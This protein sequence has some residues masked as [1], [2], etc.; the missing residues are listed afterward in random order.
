MVGKTS[1]KRPAASQAGSAAK[2]PHLEKG[3]RQ[4]ENADGALHKSKRRSRPVTAPV[5]DDSETDD[6]GDDD[7]EGDG[8]DEPLDEEGGAEDDMAVD[9]PARPKDPQGPLLCL[10]GLSACGAYK[11]LSISRIS[12]SS[13]GPFE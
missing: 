7:L 10:S 12:Q 13:A 5:K 11:T 8:L 9:T 1:K 3:Y 2:K 6:E 4:S